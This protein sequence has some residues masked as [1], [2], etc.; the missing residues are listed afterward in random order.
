MQTNLRELKMSSKT[1]WVVGGLV[2]AVGAVAYLSY[3]ETPSGKDAAGTIVAAK[4]AYVDGTSGSGTG[5]QTGTSNTGSDSSGDTSDRS[6]GAQSVKHSVTYN[7]WLPNAAARYAIKSN[8]SVY[9][10]FAEG[11]AIPPSAVFDVPGGNVLTP[12]HPT[13]AKNYQVGSVTKHRRWTLD[14]DAYYVH[15]QNG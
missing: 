7:S 10:Q 8:W 2:L 4:R 1:V 11:S 5:S 3:H 13:I 15:F 12:P 9:A 14:V 6:G